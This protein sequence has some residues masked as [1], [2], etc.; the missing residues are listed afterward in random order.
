MHNDTAGLI[1]E[2]AT[3]KLDPLAMR[4]LDLF[5]TAYGAFAGNMALATLAHGGVFLGGGIAPKIASHL[6][7]GPFMR[8]FT[9]KGRFS[10]L[11][12]TI[13]VYVIMNPQV[14]LYGALLE[15]NRLNAIA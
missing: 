4:A 11:L 6:R 9:N 7:E 12:A 2:F 13:P 3:A 1:A 5:V 10:D 15:A 8:A 14:G